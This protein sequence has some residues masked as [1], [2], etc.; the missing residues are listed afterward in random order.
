MK[1]ESTFIKI[2]NAYI[3]IRNT[4]DWTGATKEQTGDVIDETGKLTE[5]TVN[6]LG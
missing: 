4:C 1:K 6:G 3:I 5:Y 2:L